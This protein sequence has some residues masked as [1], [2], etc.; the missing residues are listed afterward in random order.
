M[1]EEP[2]YTI[3][4]MEKALRR[5]EEAAEACEKAGEFFANAAASALAMFREN[6]SP[7]LLD[8][9]ISMGHNGMEATSWAKT[10][11]ETAE[12]MK[13]GIAKKK[14]AGNAEGQQ[15]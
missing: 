2:I 12:R 7:E 11:R 15:K 4:E 14:N 1:R 6:E 9:F 13:A 10:L 5:T 3:D 8:K